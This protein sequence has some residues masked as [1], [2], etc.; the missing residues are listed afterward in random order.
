MDNVIEYLVEKDSKLKSPLVAKI[1][2]DVTEMNPISGIVM[3]SAVEVL[4][5]ETEDHPL[6][7]SAKQKLDEILPMV[8]DAQSHLIELLMERGSE[9]TVGPDGQMVMAIGDL[10]VAL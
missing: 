3:M 10:E 2:H 4:N 8:R 7:E 1:L 6:Y 9:V 5:R